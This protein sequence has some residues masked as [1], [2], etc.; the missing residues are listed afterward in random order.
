M[1][2]FAFIL[3]LIS[4]LTIG[5]G[6][7][8]SSAEKERRAIT[9]EIRLVE[10][11]G[12]YVLM[13]GGETLTSD[14]VIESPAELGGALVPPIEFFKPLAQASELE[15]F[16][17][18]VRGPIKNILMDK[19]SNILVY[20][21]VKRDV[22]ENVE[23]A[24]DKQVQ[25]AVREFV[26]KYGGD[27]IKADEA[28]EAKG[29][30][31]KSFGEQQKK[32][33]L[34]QWYVSKKMPNNRPIAHS[35]LMECYNQIKDEFFAIPAILQF[36]LIDI[37]SG[38]LRSWKLSERRKLARLIADRLLTR[39]KS[40]ED[41]GKLAM[42]YSH[43]PMREFGGLWQP[44]R[45][46]SLAAPYDML[47]AEAETIEPGQ[48]TGLIVTDEHVFIMKL[49]KKQSFGYEP[50]VKVQE[51][52]RTKI[53]IDRRNEVIDE[54]NA[55]FLH[56]AQLSKTDE[57]V[58]FCLDKIYQMRNQAVT[59]KRSIYKGTQTER[60]KD[61]SM[62]LPGGTMGMPRNIGRR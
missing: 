43:G 30:D 25:K 48:I 28:L 41:F 32:T 3:M 53:F 15:Q 62:S 11:T 49:E 47:V 44:V 31:W 34:I 14:E 51:Q 22:G 13:I 35:E 19:I 39:I 21:E 50:F 52:V 59:V 58:D 45:P 54:V 27:Q 2:K 24:L 29:M 38:P 17:E 42:Q 8:Q 60:R 4:L 20:Q 23:M 33:M 37:Q 1:L 56:Q 18:R 40:G 46:D 12:G 10:A 61:G 9:Q 36:R 6:N 16:K 5:C 57:F 7:S 55:E 26:M